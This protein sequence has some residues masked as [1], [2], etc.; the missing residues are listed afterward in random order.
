RRGRGKR[1]GRTARRRPL[2][3]RAPSRQLRP[4][5]R[6]APGRAPRRR[7]RSAPEGLYAEL[8]AARGQTSYAPT[9]TSL[10]RTGEINATEPNFV[11]QLCRGT[12]VATL[13][14][15]TDP[16]RAR[17]IATTC[18]FS[19]RLNR[20]GSRKP[21]YGGESS[22]AT[23]CHA[24]LPRFAANVTVTVGSATGTLRRMYELRSSGSTRRPG[25]AAGRAAIA[26]SGRRRIAETGGTG[27]AS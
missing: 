14:I 8:R 15:A 24:P 3:A 27:T 16:S 19:F 23:R 2:R 7:S 4:T 6:H 9:L 18:T 12:T 5:P 22:D 26:R 20:A 1:S 13:E 17:S 25:V 10:V 21:R 11:D